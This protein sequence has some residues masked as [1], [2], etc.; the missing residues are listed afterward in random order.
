MYN[1]PRTHG[2]WE[3]TAP[4]PPVTPALQGDAVADV[5]VVGGGFTGQSAALHLAEGGLDVILL[6][7]KE[8]GFGGAGRNVGLINGG[9]WVMPKELPDVLGETYGERL[10]DLLGDAPL[11]VRE[12]VEKHG[13]PCEI[14]KNGTLHC[15]VGEKGLA[16]I[17]ERCE[18]W[19]ARGAPVRVLDADETASYIGSTAYSGALLDSRAGTIQPLA[20]VRGLAGAALKAGVR[21]HTASPVNETGRN[22]AKWVVK[23]PE[24][25]VTA[26]WIV[27]A[28][29]AYSTG[30][31]Q[32]IREE[33]VY[34]PYFNF[35]TR[36]L[37]D[38]LQKSILPGRQGCWD[39][40]EILSSFRMD[41][42]GRLV[43]GSVGA[44]RGTGAAI[45]RA[46]AKR[47]LKRLFPQLGDTEFECEW[48]GQIGMTANAVPRFH[49]FAE[50]VVG[51]S[52]YNGRGI[53]PGTAFGKV[54]AQHILG[55]I[56][57]AD[58]PLPVTEP[59]AQALRA[60]KEAY[61]EAGAQI[62]HFAGERF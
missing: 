53:A 22:G 21:L 30:P 61:Y 20:Y 48:Y 9:M 27:V 58:L 29:E 50:N 31:W 24:G 46:W 13:I 37:S 43:F 47:S 52:G 39:T 11:L 3:K 19:S 45:H 60:V 57:E 16:E 1:D 34:L 28:T 41:K 4:Q 56:A 49:K 38:N 17:R 12:L 32:I 7:A 36:P 2:L 26:K 6:E 5:V 10:L 55:E 25:S 8:I 51:F 42:A 59:K 15:A 33:Q 62:A 44:L 40:K 35:A 54:I 23:T 14:E 18:Q